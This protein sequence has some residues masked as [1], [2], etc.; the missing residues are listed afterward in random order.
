M[1]LQN[2]YLIIFVPVLLV[3]LNKDHEEPE[4]EITDALLASNKL[5]EWQGT[6][7]PFKTIIS[8]WWLLLSIF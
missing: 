8:L 5:M 7:K 2:R 1:S 4:V 3:C 6:Y